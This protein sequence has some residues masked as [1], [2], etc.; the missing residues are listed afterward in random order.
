MR[1]QLHSLARRSPAECMLDKAPPP[2]RLFSSR[3]SGVDVLF[4]GVEFGHVVDRSIKNRT[5][6]NIED[7]EA[8]RAAT[9]FSLLLIRFAL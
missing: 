5:L 1:L 6:L 8:S 4:G 2:L 9:K 7:N 3:P